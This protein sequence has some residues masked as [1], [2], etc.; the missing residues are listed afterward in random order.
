M[1]ERR[2][3]RHVSVLNAYQPFDA[4]F[5]EIYFES[6]DLELH[7]GTRA[8]RTLETSIQ[9]PTVKL[10]VLTGDAG[11]GKTHLCGQLLA[12]LRNTQVSEVADDLKRNGY[13]TNDLAILGDGRAVRIVKDLSESDSETGAQLISD[14]Y[15]ATNR[16][17]IICANEG[18]LR[19]CIQKLDFQALEQ[20]LDDSILR[21]VTTSQDGS[22]R[23]LDLNHQSVAG[24]DDD[25]TIV[26]QLL[27][28]WVRDDT[29]WSDCEGCTARQLCPI[30]NNRSEL[31]HLGPEGDS[32]REAY[33]L[34]LRVSERTGHVITIRELLIATSHMI[35]AGL[36]C[37]PVHDR[38]H[39]RPGDTGWQHEFAFH[40]AIFGDLVPG[41]F[42]ESLDI[43][44]ALTALDP[45]RRA[46]RQVD[47]RLDPHDDMHA[48]RFSPDIAPSSRPAP[49]TR[50]QRD[51]ESEAHRLH[52]RFMRRRAFFLVDAVEGG[53]NP[54]PPA[55]GRLGLWHL[56]D[57]EAI[58]AN[59]TSQRSK[60]ARNQLLRG[61]ES[62]Q[63]V[64]RTGVENLMLVDPAFSSQM[65]SEADLL[66]PTP[67]GGTGK[68]A[69]VVAGE[70]P[71]SEIRLGSE[72]A[73]WERRVD[74]GTPNIRA[75]VDWIDR[76]VS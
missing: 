14:A 45:A 46:L 8:F 21:G 5:G 7:L 23:I 73:V 56:D 4:D 68:G 71:L 29:K 57:F 30:V 27:D 44:R 72:Y 55:A 20:A 48:G 33:R 2:I 16:L 18:R 67:A 49:K 63:G 32:R 19:A 15:F 1:N 59:P 12:S 9:D 41:T 24:V 3:N 51:A 52:W 11:H 47:D 34:L 53:E 76:R 70:V 50:G 65:G 62:V 43:F 42:R 10:V 74:D 28:A 39:E 40:Q 54:A 75:D 6:S 64:R 61:L 37:E 66:G 38:V 26:D 69:V 25:T 31:A 58:I 35:T 13:G 36:R 60:S 17:T 22:V